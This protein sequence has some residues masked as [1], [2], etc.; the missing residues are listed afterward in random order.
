[1]S[2]LLP[3][4]NSQADMPLMATPTS[5][6]IDTVQP[7]TGLGLL[8]RCTASQPIA[9]HAIISSSALNSAARI[10]ELRRP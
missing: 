9:P 8:K 3:A 4:M 6:T 5:A 7:A 2:S 1:M 10:D